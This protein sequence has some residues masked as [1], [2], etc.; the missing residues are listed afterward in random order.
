MVV[1]SRRLYRS[2]RPGWT[3]VE[4]LG[5]TVVSGPVTT[6]PGRGCGTPDRRV[7]GRTA[8][9]PHGDNI[10][11]PGD[12]GHGAKPP[13]WRRV[14]APG[15]NH[16]NSLAPSKSNESVR[17]R[18]ALTALSAQQP[19]SLSSVLLTGR[20]L[21]WRQAS[22]ELP[23]PC[24]TPALTSPLACQDVSGD[25]VL[26]ANAERSQL[27]LHRCWDRCAF[28]PSRTGWRRDRSKP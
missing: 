9:P 7:A 12:T 2:E 8:T 21:A 26:A 19:R 24:K 28:M 1:G 5:H 3:G 20:G 16:Q 10:L 15:A 13:R 18:L 22:C 4:R 25:G 23:G 6:G 27:D 14:P 17:F 11:P